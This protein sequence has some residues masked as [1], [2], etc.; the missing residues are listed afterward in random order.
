[1]LA[2][3]C[4]G[5]YVKF[6]IFTPKYLNYIFIICS[7]QAAIS[8]VSSLTLRASTWKLFSNLEPRMNWSITIKWKLLPTFL[9]FYLNSPSYMKYCSIYSVRL[10]YPDISQT[11]ELT[12]HGKLSCDKLVTWQ[13]SDTRDQSTL[14]D[15]ETSPTTLTVI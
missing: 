8:L 3:F 14:S 5:W 15:I 7:D 10:S 6:F 12:G 1:M 9:C 13:T 2:S 4:T 11:S